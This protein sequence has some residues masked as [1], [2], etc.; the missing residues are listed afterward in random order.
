[1]RCF[2]C[3]IVIV[4]NLSICS[5]LA[6][7]KDKNAW[8]FSLGNIHLFDIPKF[9]NSL[10][11]LGGTEE[12]SK[13]SESSVEYSCKNDVSIDP[14]IIEDSLLKTVGVKFCVLL[15][16]CLSKCIII[17]RFPLAGFNSEI[18]LSLGNS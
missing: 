7:E 18:W 16:K 6:A 1:M 12:S 3:L 5:V 14:N 4:V 11:I 8:S 15:K 10:S 2:V 17:G 9:S 13:S